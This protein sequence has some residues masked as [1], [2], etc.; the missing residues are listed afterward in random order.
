MPSDSKAL[1]PI[2]ESYRALTQDLA[3]FQKSMQ[4]NLGSAGL[5]PFDLDRVK[6]PTGGGLSWSVPTLEGI[7]PKET[8]EG[9][10]VYWAEPRAYYKVSF[11]QSGG[12]SPPDCSSTDGL[13]GTGDNGTGFGNH[14]CET[15]P[16]NQWG[17]ATRQGV[18]AKGKACRQYRGLYLLSES[19]G[20]PYG[21]PLPPTSIGVMRKF[22]LRLAS[23][24][25]PY[26]G[27]V[28]ALGLEQTKSQGNITYSVVAPKLVRE[29]NETE[30][31]RIEAYI[32]AVRPLLDRS[33]I[34]QPLRDDESYAAAS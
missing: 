2:T 25:I 24:N 27:A 5:N 19:A 9:V 26:F 16:Q 31:A 20:L 13:V 1:V 6:I 11:D 29:L 17:T 3:R 33:V 23:Q 8:L 10:I 30:L 32:D 34:A 12:G 14:D 28:V 22:F 15:C 4:A 21:V 18:A 7:K